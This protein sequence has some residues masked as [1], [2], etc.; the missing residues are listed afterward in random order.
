MQE[1]AVAELRTSGGWQLG[2]KRELVGERATR[3]SKPSTQRVKGPDFVWINALPSLV[4]AGIEL[5]PCCY[6]RRVAQR[7]GDPTALER[8]LTVITLLFHS[9]LRFRHLARKPRPSVLD[10]LAI[11]C[12]SGSNRR[13]SKVLE[14]PFHEGLDLDLGDTDIPR[15]T[16]NSNYLQ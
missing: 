13:L 1:C 4:P 10:I 9:N 8:M 5:I 12:K 14:R 7:R 3:G 16:G 2:R 6:R 11:T 15:P